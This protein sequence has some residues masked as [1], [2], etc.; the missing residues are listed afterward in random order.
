MTY[1]VNWKFLRT[2]SFL[3][4]LSSSFSS[5]ADS[6]NELESGQE[7]V[8]RQAYCEINSGHFARC[9]VC[10]FES[11]RPLLCELYVRGQTL[12]GYWFEGKKKAMVAPGQCM[13]GQVF[14][15]NPMVDPLVTADAHA[16][17]NP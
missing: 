16:F 4:L 9:E 17:C 8:R 11:Y 14:A 7:S 3:F 15:R 10:N 1:K 2:L 13:Y 12:Y 5:L 6:V